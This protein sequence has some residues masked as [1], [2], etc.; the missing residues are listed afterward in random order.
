MLL[1]LPDEVLT[2]V[3][4]HLNEIAPYQRCL[5]PLRLTCRRLQ[6]ISRPLVF[7]RCLIRTAN[8]FSALTKHLSHRP[9]DGPFV[10]CMSFMP[11]ACVQQAIHFMQLGIV[12]SACTAL[13]SLYITLAHRQE[14]LDG[15]FQFL[16]AAT[17]RSL[18]LIS[19]P[20]IGQLRDV[21]FMPQIQFTSLLHLSLHDFNISMFR[22]SRLVEHIE[23]AVSKP[24]NLASLSIMYSYYEN[25]DDAMDAL[26]LAVGIA[27]TQL[28]S[29]TLISEGCHL[30]FT[31]D[32]KRI[33][34]SYT[35]LIYLRLSGFRWLTAD[36]LLRLPPTLQ[37][38]NLDCSF[39][40]DPITALMAALP[41]PA[42]LPGLRLLMIHSFPARVDFEP[43]EDEWVDEEA[44]RE[45]CKARGI[46]L[47]VD[48]ED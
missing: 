44:L 46:V 35:G 19:G 47:N 45:R 41:N 31:V 4:W 23:P 13:T 5:R 42:S 32:I 17:L 26:H 8:Y 39:E 10:R 2:L 3:V 25:S 7:S 27:N 38:F 1:S 24:L 16:P 11:G 15:L 20:Q 33:L 28:S 37:Q 18:T 29:L 48:D 43:L 14:A 9:A 40:R 34:A 36:D 22:T 30:H 21:L 6:E 12:L